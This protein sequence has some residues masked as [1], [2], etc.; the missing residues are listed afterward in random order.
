[1]IEFSKKGVVGGITVAAAAAVALGWLTASLPSDPSS[2]LPNGAT[3]DHNRHRPEVT[4]LA[5]ASLPAISAIEKEKTQ[6][7]FSPEQIQKMDQLLRS[8]GRKTISE[9]YQERSEYFG[10]M[11]KINEGCTRQE[12]LDACDAQNKEIAN[13]FNSI[14]KVLE[15]LNS[16]SIQTGNSAQADLQGRSPHEVFFSALSDITRVTHDAITCIPASTLLTA[17]EK[18]KMLQ[19]MSVAISQANIEL[20]QYVS[21]SFELSESTAKLN[22][23]EIL[24]DSIANQNL[25]E[26]Q[27]FKDYLECGILAQKLVALGANEQTAFKPIDQINQPNFLIRLSVL[28]SPAAH[29]ELFETLE[30]HWQSKIDLELNAKRALK[31]E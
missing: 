14:S 16:S 21:R 31:A 19:Q 10:A 30:V 18:S 29:A 20:N 5:K 3:P 17:E 1:M 6:T 24:A 13:A 4:N 12:H 11:H 23:P 2:S 8:L 9:I 25:P 22:Q 28:L 7:A 26:Y 15:S 27:A